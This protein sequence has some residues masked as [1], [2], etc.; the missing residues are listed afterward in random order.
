MIARKI[1]ATFVFEFFR[2]LTTSRIA[3]S[4]VLALFAPVMLTLIGF[5]LNIDGVRHQIPFPLLLIGVFQLLAIFLSVL[6]WATPV[7]YSELEGKTWTYLAIRPNGKFASTLGKYF[8]AVFW[9]SMTATVSLTLSCLVISQFPW[10][11]DIVIPRR[12]ADQPELY[13]KW[14]GMFTHSSSPI[15]IWYSLFPAI[16]L[17]AF[18]LS[19][20]FIHIGLIAHKRGMV[21][22]VIY[23]IIETVFAFLPA[24]VRQFTVG[25]HLR[26]IG[27]KLADFDF[28]QFDAG[29]VTDES[30]LWFHFLVLAIITGI[31]VGASVYWLHSREYITAEEA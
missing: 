5:S 31:H 20:I 8:N 25:F 16:V 11:P 21:F 29:V 6:L 15:V 7:V 10:D 19:A 28:E 18:A 3:T 30:G 13:E 1:L 4:A 27:L 17:G 23:G 22:A 24:V 12:V 9:A 14:H 26:N 2:S